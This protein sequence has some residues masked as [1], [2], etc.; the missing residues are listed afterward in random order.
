[1]EVRQKAVERRVT[2]GDVAV[3]VV[4]VVTGRRQNLIEDPVLLVS[5]QVF[6]RI[7]GPAKVPGPS[8]G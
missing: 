7:M 4:D 6:L 1:M 8:A 2:V 3:G 5:E